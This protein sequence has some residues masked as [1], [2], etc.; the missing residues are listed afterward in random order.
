MDQVKAR[1]SALKEVKLRDCG[2]GD[3]EIEALFALI[4]ATLEVREQLEYINVSHNN[5][6]QIFG[7]P[8][9][10]AMLEADFSYNNITYR[11]YKSFNESQ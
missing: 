3:T 6:N 7:L 5:L 9:M 11:D 2:L 4:D 10:S 8:S 1:Y